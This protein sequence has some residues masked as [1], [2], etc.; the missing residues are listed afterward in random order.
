[1]THVNQKFTPKVVT[2][3]E[4][5]EVAGI[6]P[7]DRESSFPYVSNIHVLYISYNAENF[8]HFLSDELFPA[9]SMLEAFGELDY[10]VQMVR[11]QV[12]PPLEVILLRNSPFLILQFLFSVSYSHSGNLPWISAVLV[13]LSAP[14]LGRGPVEKVPVPVPYFPKNSSPGFFGTFHFYFPLFPAI[15]FLAPLTTL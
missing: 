7:E 14:E 11:V 9:Y 4:F 6:G 8:G 15:V 13:R 10:N 1:M 2:R 3:A 5:A 12:D